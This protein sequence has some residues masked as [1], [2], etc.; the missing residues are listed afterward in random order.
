[1]NVGEVIVKYLEDIGVDTVFGGSG[2]SI[3]S[4]LFALDGS[5]KIKTIIPRNEQAASFMACG[6][7]MFSDKPGVCFSS[8]GP[9]AVN[10]LSGLCV[11]YSDSL[12]ILSF[13]A[14][15][16]K[17]FRGMGD[18]GDSGGMNRTP[19]GQ[20]IFSAATKKSFI[21]ENPEYT[22]DILEEAI[23][24]MFEGRPGPVN[25]N[26]DYSIFDAEVKNYRPIKLVKNPV[27]ALQK[28]VDQFAEAIAE[29]IRND[30][31]ILVLLGYGCVRSKAEKTVQAF[32]EEYQL[33]FCTT[34][35][36]KGLLPEDHAL[37]LGVSGVSGDPG[38]KE[39]LKSAD[40]VIAIGNSFTKWAT[41]RFRKDIFDQKLLF[42][43]NI[44]ENEINKVYKADYG[45]VSD[46]GPAVSAIH[47][48]LKTLVP[49]K[50][51][52]V[53]GKERHRDKP[54][55]QEGEKIHPGMLAKEI[56]RL[57]PEKSI[58]LGDAGNH[59][60]WLHAFMSLNEGQNYQNPG[61]FGPMAANVNAAVGVKYANPDRPVVVACGDG[62][63]QMSGFE[64]MTAVEHNVPVVWIIF[65][66]G[67]YNIIKMFNLLV[68][69]KEVF[70]HFKNPD[71]SLYA[72]SCG[73]QGYLVKEIGEFEKAFKE[74]L[75][76]GKPAL[77]DVVVDPDVYPPFE[78]YQKPAG[79]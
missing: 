28:K 48:K 52:K 76:S 44:D 78:P 72:K 27:L 77:I 18:L 26:V 74:A 23:H 46:A 34:M 13:P 5:E 53:F 43:I 19:D 51:K 24:L 41:W 30:K 12:P 14:F 1:M 8:A 9:G 49:E 2:Q 38:V 40:A 25:I 57:L 71:F 42:H 66:N 4:L 15:T 20:A 55:V 7:A 65:N 70:N 64:L 22:C 75:A 29:I 50:S 73:A 10:M 17:E 32:L 16:P 63:Y 61:S 47:D 45:M 56:S 67:D 54:L 21:L 79:D 58:I 31:K 62:D 68:K 11:A 6:Y 60:L 69:G 36:G 33:P 37:C 3:S 35:D 39:Y 59:M